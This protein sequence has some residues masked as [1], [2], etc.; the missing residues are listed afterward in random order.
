MC[1]FIFQE[2][3]GRIALWNVW[4]QSL[5]DILCDFAL[6]EKNYA[7]TNFEP[8]RN[9]IAERKEDKVLA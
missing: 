8:V 4:P 9:K 6:A 3:H 1:I 2:R 5:P 7:D